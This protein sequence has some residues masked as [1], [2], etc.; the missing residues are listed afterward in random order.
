MLM[1]RG[2]GGQVELCPKATHYYVAY[3][4]YK[5]V[6]SSKPEASAHARLRLSDKGGR[7]ANGATYIS[8]YGAWK[9]DLVPC[10]ASNTWMEVGKIQ[11][12]GSLFLIVGEKHNHVGFQQNSHKCTAP[13]SIHCLWDVSMTMASSHKQH[14]T[15]YVQ[16]DCKTCKD[17]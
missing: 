3:P 4:L 11:I 10:F 17:D 13:R 2:Q 16:N 7:E 9:P 6:N 14:Q 8:L 12:C 15:K 1:L 5:A